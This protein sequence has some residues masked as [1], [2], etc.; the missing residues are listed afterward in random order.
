MKYVSFIHYQLRMG[1]VG[2]SWDK[3][4]QNRPS[5]I[6]YFIFIL[7]YIMGFPGGLVVKNSPANAGDMG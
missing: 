3:F 4:F 2:S 6:F 7:P 5:L 1:T